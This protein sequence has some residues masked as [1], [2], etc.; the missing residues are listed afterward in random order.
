MTCKD[1]VHYEACKM[2]LLSAYPDVTEVEIK[3][4]VNNSTECD[5]FKDKA[6]FV[7][8]PCK[9]RDTVY[10]VT[11]IYNTLVDSAEEAEKALRANK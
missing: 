5:Q 11:G 2:I 8:L 7:E 3:Q 1:C 6:R 10:Y 4:T 9:V